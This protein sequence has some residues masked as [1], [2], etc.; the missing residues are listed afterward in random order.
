M[1]D[2]KS[3]KDLTMSFLHNL[4]SSPTFLRVLCQVFQ[5]KKNGTL[6]SPIFIC[7]KPLYPLSVYRNNR[8]VPIIVIFKLR[9][10]VPWGHLT[11]L[12]RF[13]Q[14]PLVGS[15]YN[16]TGRHSLT[17]IQ[18]DDLSTALTAC[19]PNPHHHLSLFFQPL[20]GPWMLIPPY[21]LRENIPCLWLATVVLILRCPLNPKT[22]FQSCREIRQWFIPPSQCISH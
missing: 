18:Q 7:F 5:N 17:L 20:H 21:W 3:C 4:R 9:R 13:R 22:Y 19:S 6:I 12:S 1:L 11:S 8:A 10:P 14:K 16:L 2:W 15:G